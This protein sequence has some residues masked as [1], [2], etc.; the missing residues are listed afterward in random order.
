MLPS[1]LDLKMHQHD[2]NQE[3]RARGGGGKSHFLLSLLRSLQWN[4]QY[5]LQRVINMINTSWVE[6]PTLLILG[7]D[8]Q[9]I[10]N[11]AER[12]CQYIIVYN[13]TRF[14]L[15]FFF[16]CFAADEASKQKSKGIYCIVCDTGLYI[17]EG[18]WYNTCGYIQT[19]T[20]R[21]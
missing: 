7:C 15:T 2:S 19:Y 5:I 17:C 6:W 12:A 10:W 3:D 9:G 14:I 11:R 21:N 16:L 13:K 20:P 8:M 4:W 18:L 1:L